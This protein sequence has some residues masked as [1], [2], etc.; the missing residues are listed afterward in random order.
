[1]TATII[2]FP[3]RMA[4]VAAGASAGP[5]ATR[6]RRVAPD[7]PWHLRDRKSVV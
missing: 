5:R 6:E 1:M 4:E 7:A 3:D 2:P